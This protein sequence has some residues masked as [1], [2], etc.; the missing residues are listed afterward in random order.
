MAATVP[1]QVPNSLVDRLAI[2]VSEQGTT[3]TIAVRGEWDLGERPA[4]REAIRTALE[5]DPECVVLDLSGLSFIDSSG[6][7]VVTEL[8]KRSAQQNVRLV[9]IP[10]PRAVH[11]L[12]EICHLTQALSFASRRDAGQHHQS[13]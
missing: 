7:H 3:T 1:D 4:T 11:R 2:V 12:F 10:G 5:R 13:P 8:R 6:L 9:I